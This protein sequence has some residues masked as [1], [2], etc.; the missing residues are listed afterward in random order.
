MQQGMRRAST[1][2]QVNHVAWRYAIAGGNWLEG[3]RYGARTLNLNAN[4]WNANGNVGVR[5][6]SDAVAADQHPDAR[7]K[8]RVPCIPYG[9]A[10]SSQPG[11]LLAGMKR[12]CRRKIACTQTLRVLD[13]IID[14]TPCGVGI[15]VGNLTSQWLANLLGNEIDQWIKRD[16][17]VKRYL[18]YMD[19]MVA[20]FASQPE[21]A[22]FVQQVEARAAHYGLTYSKWS[23]H[24]ATQGINALGYRI[25]PTHK[26]LRRRAIVM[27]RRDMHRLARGR[28]EGW[29]SIDQVTSR[30]KAFVAHAKHGDTWR[31]RGKLFSMLGR[32]S[33]G[34]HTARVAI[35]IASLTQPGDHHAC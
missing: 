30:V 11:C 14:S 13:A 33:H 7:A 25:W 5:G 31:L 28:E 27:F 20:I 18:R 16:L 34:T 1:R 17:R 8:P 15:P 29:A 19:D 4:A 35:I 32:A 6:V 26:L 3:V 9:S 23:V 21:A 12:V 24:R 10:A 2:G 22:L